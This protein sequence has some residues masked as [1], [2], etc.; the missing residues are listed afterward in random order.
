M[1]YNNYCTMSDI[2]DLD[3]RERAGMEQMLMNV[4]EFERASK[5]LR[6]VHDMYLYMC[7]HVSISSRYYVCA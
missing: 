5:L 6:C 4:M 3:K 7:V 2:G 1:V